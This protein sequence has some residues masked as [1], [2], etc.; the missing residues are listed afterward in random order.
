MLRIAFVTPIFPTP[1][2]PFRG[3]Y[4][5]KLVESLHKQADVEASCRWPSLPLPG[6]QRAEVRQLY[7]EP[8]RRRIAGAADDVYPRY[9]SIRFARVR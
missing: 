3:T 1:K 9:P 6:F 4:N 8:A 2:E 5:Y 7:Q